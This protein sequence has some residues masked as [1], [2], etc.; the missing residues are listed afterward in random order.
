MR[1]V[2]DRRVTPIV[3]LQVGLGEFVVGL[4]KTWSRIEARSEIRWRL[5]VFALLKIG[6]AP[7][8]MLFLQN[9]RMR[10]NNQQTARPRN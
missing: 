10:L 1:T 5:P 3:L 4:R 9:L 2:P 8:E 7:I 6:L